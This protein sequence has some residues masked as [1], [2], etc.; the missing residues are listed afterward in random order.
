MVQYYG[1]DT[2]ESRKKEYEEVY[3]KVKDW[4]SIWPYTGGWEI[5]LG[6]R[7]VQ[8]IDALNAYKEKIIKK[9]QS[10]DL[11]SNVDNIAMEWSYEID[12]KDGR[13]TVYFAGC[14][15]GTFDIMQ[16]AKRKARTIINIV[17]QDIKDELFTIEREIIMKAVEKKE[18]ANV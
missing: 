9:I 10:D 2:I 13:V 7:R 17:R 8:V 16:E 1:E 6:M 4:D 3:G 18:K 14:C 11:D 5:R 15:F 12:P